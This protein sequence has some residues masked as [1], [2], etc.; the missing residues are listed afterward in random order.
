MQDSYIGILALFITAVAAPLAVIFIGQRLGPRRPTPDLDTVYPARPRI[1]LK[2][3]R[4]AALFV[5]FGVGMVFMYLWA[6]LFL[7]V[8]E[9][10][11]LFVGLLI[12]VTMLSIGY[13][14]AWKK[15]ALEWE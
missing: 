4:I 12:F 15:G 2:L 11:F 1:P 3:Y 9:K 10:L 8:D 5:L 6:A 7:N 14:Y 13:A